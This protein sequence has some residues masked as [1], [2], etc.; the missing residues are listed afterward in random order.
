MRTQYLAVSLAF[1]ACVG[2][3][4]AQDA[5]SWDHGKAAGTG[6]EREDR[7]TQPRFGN[8]SG[9]SLAI[10]TGRVS[11]GPEFL[12]GEPIFVRRM[13]ERDGMTIV[14]V[15]TTPFIPVLVSNEESRGVRP[16]QPASW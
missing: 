1:V 14:E 2:P 5:R 12:D 9:I 15:S 7:P 11:V 3:A 10:P 16:D 8:S 4:F 6:V 13:T